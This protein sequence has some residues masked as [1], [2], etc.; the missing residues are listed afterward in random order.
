ML[1]GIFLVISYNTTFKVFKKF[2][3]VSSLKLIYFSD[4]ADSLTNHHNKRY[5]TSLEV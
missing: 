4:L 2:W 3:I 1:R 5:C